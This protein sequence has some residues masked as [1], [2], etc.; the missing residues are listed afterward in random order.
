MIFNFSDKS[1]ASA[2]LVVTAAVA[3]NARLQGGE[4]STLLS[5]TY[6]G[7]A[8]QHESA[9]IPR[10]MEAAMRNTIESSAADS[11]DRSL[12]NSDNNEMMNSVSDEVDADWDEADVGLL[13]RA[14]EDERML[15]PAASFNCNSCDERPLIDKDDSF[16][17]LVSYC[18]DYG[19][20]DVLCPGPLSCWNT[21][22]V[23][24][25]S[26]AFYN[27]TTFNEPLNCWDTFSVKSFYDMFD[28]AYAFDQ[29]ISGWRTIRVTDMSYMFFSATNFNSDISD[30]NTKNVEY[31][32]G[33]FYY[34]ENFNQRIGQWDV[35]STYEL[36][37][38]FAYATSF[39]SAVNQWDTSKVYNFKS[40]FE[41]ASE[42][43]V[44]I[45]GWNTTG[46]YTMYAMFYG[47]DKFNRPIDAWDTVTVTNMALMFYGT[48][49]NQPLDSWK[50]VRVETMYGMFGYSDFN[51]NIDSWA[52]KNVA[53]MSYMFVNAEYFNQCLP[54]WPN[55]TPD[56]VNTTDMFTNTS[57]PEEGTPD[58]TEGPWCRESCDFDEPGV[59]DDSTEEFVLQGDTTTCE[60]ISNLK[61]KKRDKKCNKRAAKDNCPGLCEDDCQLP[62]F[63]TI[64]DDFL[65]GGDADKPC[66]FVLDN[67]QRC[68][69]DKT[70]NKCR[71]Y[72]DPECENPPALQ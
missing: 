56:N 67:P 59:C 28:K 61:R 14:Y 2:A 34:A 50:T 20:D 31:M 10:K 27:R 13:D 4:S 63:C 46:A 72:C 52:T 47:A 1:F 16:E 49:F 3:A 19:Y 38:M 24:D 22:E 32:G 12:T 18:L 68:N 48:S 66:E 30:W 64:D 43:N 7:D 71:L 62:D 69:K 9:F 45:D 29:D 36:G 53:N 17:Y 44:R 35:S 8:S 60:A 54:A 15:A 23:K 37:G 21:S 26:Y 41:G 51:Q 58:P 5:E 55:R 40:V 57:C 11:V 70:F 65:I 33:M 6:S 39:N 25:M 42:F